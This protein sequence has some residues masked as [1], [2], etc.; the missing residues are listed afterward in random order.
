VVIHG[1]LAGAGRSHN[2]RP[3][4]LRDHVF[5]LDALRLSTTQ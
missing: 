5:A 4:P 1:D 3:K 2:E